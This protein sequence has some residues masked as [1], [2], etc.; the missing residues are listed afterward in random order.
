MKIF[1]REPTLWIAVLNALVI[2]IGTFGLKY[3]SGDQAALMVVVVNALFGALNAWTVR[4]I[5][6]VAFTYAIGALVALGAAY[7]LNLPTETVAALNVAVIPILALLS[8][9]QVTPETTAV[10]TSTVSSGGT[11]TE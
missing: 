11:V 2:L 4:P 6:P 5:S 3:I 10:S 1:G 7:G 8:R 9:G